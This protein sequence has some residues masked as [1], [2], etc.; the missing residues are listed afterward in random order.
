MSSLTKKHIVLSIK[1]LTEH[2]ICF[3]GCTD[4]FIGAT[5][6]PLYKALQQAVQDVA[7]V[8]HQLDVLRRAV[9]TLPVQNGTLK[10]VAELLTRT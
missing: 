5:V 7:P 8:P 2:R 6:S 9:H 10:H 3:L 1:C 4:G